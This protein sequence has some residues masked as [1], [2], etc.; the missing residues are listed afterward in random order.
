MTSRPRR[1]T[2]A[3]AAL[4]L[5][6]ASPLHAFERSE[7]REP[8]ARFDPLRQPFYGDLHVHTAL[9]FDANFIGVR[10]TPREAY[11]FARGERLGIRPYD[12]EGRPLRHVQL[13]R[14]LDFAAV[15]DHAELLGEVSLCTTPGSQAYDAYMCRLTRRWPLLA[16]VLVNSAILNQRD[17]RRYSFCGEDGARCREA[18]RGPWREIQ[19]TAEAAYDR[20][21][22]CRFTSFVGYE[23]SGNPGSSMI[24][25]NVI[26]RNERAQ[27]LPTSY[28]EVGSA[29]GLWERL[30]A[31]CRAR[32]DGCDVLAIP[33]NTNLSGGLAFRV[34]D[35]AGRPLDAATA[36][37]RA[38]LERLVE[39]IQHKG[40]SECRVAGPS[41]DELCGFELL[42]FSAMDQFPFESW[43]RPAPPRAYVREALG[44]GLVQEAR[45]GVNPFRFGLIG[46]T[47]THLGTPGLAG[48]EGY[49]G[50]AAGGDTNRTEIP[51]V[52]DRLYFNPGGLAGLWAEENARDALFDA[53]HRREAWATSGPRITVRFFG[54]WAYPE[55]LCTRPD[56]VATGYAGGVPMGGVL[57]APPG[58]A[59]APRFAIWALRDPGAEGSPGTQLQRLQ[60]VKLWLEDGVA[61]ER[62]L[63]VAGDARNGAD[64]AP[65]TCTPRGPGF[66][67]LCTLW[68]DP[69]F[70]PTVPALWYVRVLE[71][72]SCRWSAHVCRANGVRCQVPDAVPAALRYCCQPRV[73]GTIQ[74]RAWTSP[75]WYTP[76]PSSTSASPPGAKRPLQ[77]RLRRADLQGHEEATPWPRPPGAGSS[78]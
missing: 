41:E 64:V 2:G 72:P 20:S 45:L 3:L 47:D 39:V 29:Q 43:W 26:F 13:A 66:D 54:G 78:R 42:P 52:P 30:H 67:T 19:A 9:S 8:C 31:E 1:A 7:P 73:P 35:D 6:L 46:A 15:T 57:D 36:H 16:Y 74:E 68:S 22:A 33:H 14:P 69:D 53:M 28:V 4:L 62:V 10:T 48:E 23:W 11:R 44:E 24:H 37:R 32:D 65:E 5:A 21:A 34:E 51:V 50:H 77:S 71:N 17:P 75:I 40:A 55:D 59:G 60:I 49:P 18:A 12:A 70:D 76:A 61:R 25:R 58:D 38:G 56:F 63:D 27:E